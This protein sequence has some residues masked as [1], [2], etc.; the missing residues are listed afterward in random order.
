MGGNH[1]SLKTTHIPTHWIF[2]HW[3]AHNNRIAFLKPRF[4]NIFS[5]SHKAGPQKQNSSY[6]YLPTVVTNLSQ[7]L[8]AKPEIQQTCSLQQNLS[9]TS[10]H[11]WP[12]VTYVNSLKT[13]WALIVSNSLIFIKV[14]CFCFSNSDDVFFNLPTREARELSCSTT[15]CSIS[16]KRRKCLLLGS[17]EG[18]SI[19]S[20]KTEQMYMINTLSFK[21]K[22]S[23]SDTL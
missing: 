14:I 1:D 12:T 19:N 22:V 8:S 20:C 23:V 15:V 4:F 7:K 16:A 10:I 11:S 18:F 9:V 17:D 6:K 5:I 3:M 13:Y 21:S 2:F